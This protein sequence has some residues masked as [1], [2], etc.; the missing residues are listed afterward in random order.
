MY[1]LSLVGQGGKD[2]LAWTILLDVIPQLEVETVQ[3]VE[4]DLLDTEITPDNAWVIFRR[5][6][7]SP[8]RRTQAILLLS[9]LIAKIGKTEE[10]S[11]RLARLIRSHVKTL[12]DKND[13][14]ALRP[15]QSQESHGISL[16]RNQHVKL[17]L[18]LARMYLHEAKQQQ[19]V[20]K[21]TYMDGKDSKAFANETLRP[22]KLALTVIE[23]MVRFRNVLW[24]NASKDGSIHPNSNEVSN[25]DFPR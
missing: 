15:V 20:R 3:A 25:F 17:I 16:I 5:A 22:G 24:K 8:T 9:D 7:I 18:A 4:D 21:T 19:A 2:Y 11:R 13:L 6:A 14:L 1:A 23:L 12:E 10:W